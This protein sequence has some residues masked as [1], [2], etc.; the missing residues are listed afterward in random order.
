MAPLANPRH[1]RF[2][3]ALARG[4]TAG[5]AYVLAGYKANDGNASRM[6]GNEKISASERNGQYRHGER[7]KAAI[8]EERKFGVRR[9]W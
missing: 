7:T 3:Q 4:K 6:R 2:A 9:S 8:A 5:E 1:E